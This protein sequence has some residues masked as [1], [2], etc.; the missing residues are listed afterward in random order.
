MGLGYGIVS[1]GWDRARLS[2][3]VRAAHTHRELDQYEP[4]TVGKFIQ[5]HYEQNYWH[6]LP[7]AYGL[8]YDVTSN[9]KL[10]GAFTKTLE[11][12]AINSAS[13]RLITSY[14]TPVTRSISYSNPYLMP[15]R[16]T[17]F[18]ASAEY[19]Y[20]RS[21]YL[22]LG[23]FAKDLRDISASSSSQSI[24]A[25]GVREV[26]TYTSNVREVN[27]KKVYGKGAG[28][29]SGLVRS[30]VAVDP[31]ALRQSGPDAFLR[32]PRLP[33]HRDQRRWR[34]AA[35]RHPPGRQRA[36]QLLQRLA[37]LQ[38]GP[39]LRRTSIC[40]NSRRSRASATIQPTIGAPSTTRYWTCRPAGR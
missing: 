4:D 31:R 7:S 1:F 38:Q 17:N 21:A 18:D 2:A 10:R 8:A 37:G 15:I 26:I 6:V 30:A 34:H 28:P 23:A 25:D 40:R 16:S 29:G 32:L 12:P 27:G 36:A 20:G 39:R 9:L 3:G 14:D 13:R 22:S 24:G 5:S 35:Q 11:R 19:Y 33:D